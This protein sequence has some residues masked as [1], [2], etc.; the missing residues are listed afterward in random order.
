MARQAPPLYPPEGLGAPKDR[1]GHAAGGPVGLPAGTEV[2]SA[3]NHISL[4][5]DIFYERCPASLK[6]RAPRV[7]Y[8]TTPGTSASGTRRS[9]PRSSPTC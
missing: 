3:D 1:Q 6:D 5:E 2:F 4:A 8:R 7:W 9:C